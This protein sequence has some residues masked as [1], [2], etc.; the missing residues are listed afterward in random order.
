[1]WSS[2]IL[3]DTCSCVDQA[4]PVKKDKSARAET[5]AEVLPEVDV[6]ETRTAPRVDRLQKPKAPIRVRLRHKATKQPT[7]REREAARDD[8]A[9]EGALNT[10]FVRT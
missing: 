7:A 5:K 8:G 2:R 10:L 6:L 4:P 1:M 3:V 9:I